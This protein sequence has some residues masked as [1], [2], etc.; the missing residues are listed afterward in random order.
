VRVRAL[1]SVKLVNA[2]D[3]TT[4]PISLP[5]SLRFC[6]PITRR[7][8]SV[9]LVAMI[10]YNLF[11]RPITMMILVWSSRSTSL[12]NDIICHC[13]CSVC[14]ET[15]VSEVLWPSYHVSRATLNYILYSLTHSLRSANICSSEIVGPS[16]RHFTSGKVS[17]CN[18]RGREFKSRSGQNKFT[19]SDGQ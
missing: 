10:L 17:D 14:L 15:L 6:L 11:S 9:C 12:S 4:Q 1:T 3:T 13:A 5:S 7:V 8:W 16:P 18:A 2:S 19:K